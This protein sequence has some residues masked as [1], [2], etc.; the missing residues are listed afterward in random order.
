MYILPKSSDVNY[1]VMIVSE[2]IKKFSK[3]FFGRSGEL[4]A[5]LTPLIPNSTH[6]VYSAHA[7]I[8]Q[9]R[10]QRYGLK[11]T[12]HV[13]GRPNKAFLKLRNKIISEV[14]GAAGVAPI[15]YS[16]TMYDIDSANLYTDELIDD[17][18]L[19]SI[20]YQSKTALD[21]HSNFASPK[22]NAVSRYIT[23]VPDDMVWD[24][25]PRSHG[26]ISLL[27]IAS[28]PVPKG[29]FLLPEILKRLQKINIKVTL[30]LITSK[31]FKLSWTGKHTIEYIVTNRLDN[32]FKRILFGASDLLVNISPMDTLG[33][34]LDSIKYGVP[35]LTVKGQHAPCYVKSGLTGIIVDSPIFYYSE[36]LGVKY[37]DV[38][39]S[40]VKY[41]Q[42]RDISYWDALISEVV[43]NIALLSGYNLSVMKEN[44]RDYCAE[45]HSIKTWLDNYRKLYEEI[46]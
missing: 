25:N 19:V 44:H 20:L 16:K 26:A 7:K 34:F 33:T 15:E 42:S 17:G 41:I 2:S 31:E 45:N 46:T 27:V 24:K 9:P 6:P 39:K 36:D 40:F 30:R 4:N 18:R 10:T 23:Q 22:M 3:V 37:F 14:E 32:D 12:V 43:D 21:L 1:L 13:I 8:L 28:N 38:K 35:L 11:N 5:C 29:V